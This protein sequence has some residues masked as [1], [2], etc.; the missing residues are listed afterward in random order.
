MQIA[1]R[2]DVI[3][4]LGQGGMGIV[5]QAYDRLE[6]QHIALKRVSIGLHNLLFSS[7]S[8]NSNEQVAI[9]KEFSTLASLRHPHII[10][11]LDYGIADAQPF[12]TMEWLQGGQSFNAVAQDETPQGQARLLIQVLEALRYLHRRGVI[13]RDL[14]PDNVL[15][16]GDAQV[17]VLDF[18]LSVTADNARGRAG[19]LM[20]MA[21]ETLKAQIALP[22]SDLYAVGVMA[23]KMVTGDY[24]FPVNNIMA[25]ITKTPNLDALGDHPLRPII[26]RLL[27]KD[28]TDRYQSATDCIRALQQVMALP[29]EQDNRH[30]RESFLQASRFIGRDA[31]L[32]TLQMALAQMMQGDTAFY[33]VGGESG[34]GKSRLVDELRIRALVAG[35]T[36]MRGQAAEGGLP[37][38]VWRDIMRRLS[39]MVDLDDTQAAILKAIVPDIAILL[40]RDIGDAPPISGEAYQA[41]LIQAMLDVM[42]RAA[43]PLVLLLEDVQW[44]TTD[45]M[46]VLQQLATVRDQLTQVMVISTY[47]NDEAPDLPDTLPDHHLI[48]LQ[49]LSAADM[50]DLSLSI[51]G[52]GGAKQDIVQLLERETEG[53]LFFLVETMRALAEEAG[54]L[55]D[56][57]LSTLPDSV[58][59]GGMQRI[60]QRRLNKVDAAYEPIQKLAAIIGREIDSDLLA[61]HH[62]RQMVEQWL[63][64]AAQHA[65]LEIRDNRW[66][67]AHDKLRETVLVSLHDDDRQT[68]S[69][70][71]ASAIE[72]TY[73]DNHDYD[74][75]LLRHWREA[76]NLDRELHYTRRLVNTLMNV[77]AD[78]AQAHHLLNHVLARLSSDHT[79]YAVLLNQ[80]AILYRK[81]G[82][83]EQAIATAE[84]ARAVAEQNDQLMAT[85]AI[86][87]NLSLIAE[88]KGDAALSLQYGQ[89]ALEMARKLNVPR[90]IS[91]ALS[92]L[93]N[94]ARRAGQYAPSLQYYQEALGVIEAMSDDDPR[95]I[96][97]LTITTLNMGL[98]YIYLQDY[99]HAQTTLEASLQL[100]RDQNNTYLEAYALG[101]LG[102]LYYHEGDDDR[103]ETYFR[104][105]NSVREGIDD[106]VGITT[107]MVNLTF[108]LLRKGDA[109]ITAHLAQTL[110]NVIALDNHLLLLFVILAFVWYQ[111]RYHADQTPLS[112]LGFVKHHTAGDGDTQ[113]RLEEVLGYLPAD[114]PAQTLQQALL[115][116]PDLTLDDIVAHM[117]ATLADD[118]PLMTSG[119]IV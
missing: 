49:R 107:S 15:V 93:G 16:F 14:K 77:K 94:K 69:H 110:R 47:R 2:Y 4:P 21:P 28:P 17:K 64:D 31:E 82:Q 53:N 79:E 57:G 81:Q 103:A 63:M 78:Y 111:S 62:E 86:V 45:S 89:Q 52:Q 35:A 80:R 117:Q 116:Q 20:Y 27:M 24:P 112:W 118:N 50:R 9:I 105:S 11:V 66:Y 48:E 56:I 98:V 90:F 113:Q 72:A 41:R 88:E 12:F 115:P 37:Y 106:P 99:A 104:Q 67:F 3:A 51:L 91:A 55:E 25:I 30:I 71:A 59:T 60:M 19:T 36:V 87:N 92:N 70:A 84:H 29:A 10:S 108:L 38:Q 44:A 54:S 96:Y 23:Y 6:Q 58:F 5:Y 33:L 95:A 65:V 46:A 114:I 109:G 34:A 97:F 100:A 74:A 61:H 32:Q 18:G 75:V 119:A 26:E 22:Q 39:L 7:K 42:Q 43:Q 73:P 83:Y 102:V 1:N 101:N 68:L 8:A 76:S 13:H 40:A 85:A